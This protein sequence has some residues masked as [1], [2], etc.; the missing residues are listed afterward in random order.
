[1][2]KNMLRSLFVALSLGFFVN[3]AAFA[4]EM[5]VVMDGS[6]NPHNETLEGLEGELADRGFDYSETIY[7]LSG[8]LSESDIV[9]EINSLQPDVVLSMGSRATELMHREIGDIPV[10]FS[11]VLNPVEQG[12]IDNVDSPGGN[13]TGVMLNI[14]A[15]KQFEMIK[16]VLPDTERV[17]VM[18]DPMQSQQII[19]EAEEE[20]SAMG[21]S[22]LTQTVSEAAEVSNA[23]DSFISDGADVIWAIPDDTVYTS[24]SIRQVLLFSLRNEIPVAGFS[25]SFAQ[26]GAVIGI[27][28]DYFDIGRQTAEVAVRVLDGENPGNIPVVYPRELKFALSQR[29]ID[30]FNI[31]VNQ[32]VM[33]SAEHIFE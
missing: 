21:I 20:A 5:A 17:G 18:Y 1:M 28:Q 26:A 23:L 31:S 32:G 16:E 15:R 14:P 3:S 10:I 22:L 30:N 24:A 12:F 9:S 25:K 29:V 19:D 6:R 11:I 8:S 13:I 33:R 27:Y 2:S 4:A 7:D